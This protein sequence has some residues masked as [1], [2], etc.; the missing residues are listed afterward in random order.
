MKLLS[1]KRSSCCLT[2]LHERLQCSLGTSGL[3]ICLWLLSYDA[4]NTVIKPIL[5]ITFFHQKVFHYVCRNRNSSSG[6]TLTSSV[7]V[8]CLCDHSGADAL[9]PDLSGLGQ[10]PL[11]RRVPR[12]QWP[13][14]LHPHTGS[15]RRRLL[16]RKIQVSVLKS[17]SNFKFMKSACLSVT[18]VCD[19]SCTIPC[20]SGG[21]SHTQRLWW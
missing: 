19:T 5:L 9:F 13:L 21:E 2:L 8:V 10:G 18:S 16:A 17:V 14:L 4:Y 20:I 15:A 6:H 1:P 11:H 12:L 3:S 7:L